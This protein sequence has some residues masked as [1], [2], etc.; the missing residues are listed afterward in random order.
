MD[1]RGR[2]YY[3]ARFS[4]NSYDM[5]MNILKHID[6]VRL[7]S[8]TQHDFNIKIP[9]EKEPRGYHHILIG[10]RTDTSE[11]VEFELKRAK[12]RDGEFTMWKEVQ[13][14]TSK[15]YF[16]IYGQE[17]CYRKCDLNPNKRCNHCMDC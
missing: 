9:D 8:P 2:K 10:C 16:D 12:I 15:K 17:M 1:W 14:D 7:H 6:G 3:I 4:S 13:R 5:R 11:I